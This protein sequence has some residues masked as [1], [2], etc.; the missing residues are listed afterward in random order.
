MIVLYI[1]L[2][3]TV[4]CHYVKNKWQR[5]R[6]RFEKRAQKQWFDNMM[7]WLEFSK[8]DKKFNVMSLCFVC[9]WLFIDA[10][11]KLKYT[12][13]T[14]FFSWFSSVKA[15]IRIIL[16]YY[17]DLMNVWVFL[18]SFIEQKMNSR[19]PKRTHIVCIFLLFS[20][21]SVPSLFLSCDDKQ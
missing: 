17:L 18:L 5:K 19:N 21:F 8:N 3:F 20:Y 9:V 14:G 10:N 1:L 2:R 4:V 16:F 6:K 15:V 13:S 11:I 7:G 12:P